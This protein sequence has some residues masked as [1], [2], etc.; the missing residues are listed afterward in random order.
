MTNAGID[1][2][3]LI[4]RL[5]ERAADP[6]RRLEARSSQF[7]ASVA[8][9][10]LG[11]LGAALGAV[12]DDL[13]RL[14]ADPLAPPPDVAA[15]ALRL[16][17]AMQAPVATP[18]PP[19]A[20]PEQVA[21]AEAAL[22]VALPRLLRRIYLEVANGGFGPGYGILGIPPSGWGDDRGND[23]VRLHEVQRNDPDDD[24][25]GGGDRWVWPPTLLAVC[26]LGD[27]VYACV[28]A[29]RPGAPV[30]EYDPGDLEWDDDGAPVD[31]GSA[32]AEVSPSLAAWLEAW[33]A[34][35]SAAEAQAGLEEGAE[36]AVRQQMREMWAGL[37]PEEREAYGI[38]DEMLRTGRWDLG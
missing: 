2:D 9:L 4:E 23:L 36:E 6:E 35:P 3:R 13:R 8:S 29:G 7:A 15:R 37:T 16:G 1:E 20:T 5:R 33:L 32:F 19:P 34:S 12:T 27:V 26:Y 28:D 25:D 11:G 31:E 17:E 18:L 30:L 22:G 21:A 10:D 38:T 14:L 24:D